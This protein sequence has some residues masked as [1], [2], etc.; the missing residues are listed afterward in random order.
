MSKFRTKENYAFALDKIETSVKVDSKETKGI[1]RYC[2]LNDMKYFHILENFNADV[3]HDLSEGVIPFLQGNLFKYCFEAHLFTE[4]ELKNK[5]LFHDYG[6]LNSRNIPSA[7][8]I[9]RRN[10]GQ[11]ASQQK[12]LMQNLPFILH[13]YKYDPRLIRVW[14]CVTSFLEC[15]R[16]IYGAHLTDYDLDKL[17]VAISNHLKGMIQHF[18][19]ANLIRKHHY[20]LHYPNIIRAVGPVVHMSTMRFEMLHKSFTKYSRRSNNFV[21]VTQ[22]LTRNFQRSKLTEIPYQD[23]ISNAKLRDIPSGCFEHYKDILLESFENIEHVSI[24]KWLKINN[25][26]YRKG[27][28]LKE[29]NS[30]FCEIDEILFRSGN[31]YF[32]CH[33][34]ELMEFDAFLFSVEIQEK[35]T[36]KHFISKEK[37]LQVKK[38]FFKKT[39][40]NK[41]YII[42]DCLDIPIE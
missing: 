8:C 32:L 21:N 31:F 13:E 16:I 23:E 34:M 38:S 26:Y 27:L 17:E 40:E 41:F 20:M 18:P 35:K 28:I 11:N 19:G 30:S 7:I 1:V 15:S 6:V 33:E 29:N 9:D 25:N 4:E 2:M 24:T 42:A 37:T 12:C 10:L 22:S 36:K 14:H 39:V 3:M 5:A